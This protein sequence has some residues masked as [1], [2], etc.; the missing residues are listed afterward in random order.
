MGEPISIRKFIRAIEQLPSDAPVDDSGVW[1]KTQKE[2]CL[3]WL[4]CYQGSGGTGRKG[5]REKDA[6]YAYNHIVDHE[7]LLWIIQAAGVRPKLVK[8]AR[9]AAAHGCTLQ[10]RSGAIRK[11]V[12]WGELEIALW[13]G[14]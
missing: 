2:H 14:K 5:N 9:C 4:K 1:Y 6:R 7:M 10:G 12:P 8:A 3:E 13:G 11:I